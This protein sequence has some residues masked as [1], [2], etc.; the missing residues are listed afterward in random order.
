MNRIRGW[1]FLALSAGFLGSGMAAVGNPE[2]LVDVQ[3]DVLQAGEVEAW[4]NQGTLGGAFAVVPLGGATVGEVEG[5]KAVTFDGRFDMFKSDFPAPDA[6]TGNHPYTVFLRV[7]NPA[8]DPEEC[9]V[10]WARR[11]TADRA[12]QLNYGSS[13]LFGAVTHW[14]GND[15]GF[16][17]GVP[18]PGRWH[19]LAVRYAGGENGLEELFVNAELNA[20]ER[21]TLDLFTG[22]PI[23]LATNLNPRTGFSGSLAEVRIYGY[24]LSDEE[25]A[26]LH[27]GEGEADQQALVKLTAADLPPGRLERWENAGTAGGAFGTWRHVPQAAEVDGRPAVVFGGDAWLRSSF[28]W[29]GLGQGQPFTV[30]FHARAEV[31]TRRQAPL[32]F[33]HADRGE[34]LR[35]NYSANRESGALS[36]RGVEDGPSFR[37]YTPGSGAWHHIAYTWSGAPGNELRVY[38]DGELDHAAVVPMP[39]ESALHGYLGR[40][41]G[42]VWLTEEAD[43]TG[44]LADAQV[45]DRAL[46]QL[47]IRTRLGL[48]S[49]FQPAP[50]DQGSVDALQVNLQWQPGNPAAAGSDLYIGTD[51]AAVAAAGRDAEAYAGRLAADADRFG[52]LDLHLGQTYYWRVDHV[53][54]EGTVLDHGRVWSFS[55][56]TGHAT[57][58]EPR[59]GFSAVPADINTLSWTPGPFTT[60]QT[61]YFGT[62]REAVEAGAEPDGKLALDADVGTLELPNDTLQQGTIYYWRVENRNVEG[63]PV[64]AG[65]VWS[66]RTVDAHKPGHVTFLATSDAHFDNELVYASNLATI[67]MMNRIAGRELPADVGGGM[68][69]TPRGVVINGDLVDHGGHPQ[70]GPRGWAGFVEL[71]GLD[72]RDGRLAY[73]LYEGFGNHDGGPGSVVREGIKTR[74]R[75]RVGLTMVSENGYHYS[76]DWEHVHLVQLNNF[77]GS[78][79]EHATVGP[80]AHHPEHSLEFLKNTLEEH[81]GDS[82]RPVV[83]N[84][85]YGFDGWGMGWFS[86]K[87]RDL[88]YDVIKDYNVVLLIA[89]HNHAAFIGEWRGFRYLSDGAAQRG[90]RPGDFFVVQI[91]GDE[92]VI[93]QWTPDGWSNQRARV[94]IKMPE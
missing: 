30:Q 62:S 65:E 7:L 1:A 35:F 21:K 60:G 12:A 39:R 36:V 24:A 42:G 48:A 28:T 64:T 16:D 61:L 86:E 18:E 3:A 87:A 9:V 44:A 34:F 77:A 45:Y 82:G 46:S 15:M 22:D 6:V 66:F 27:A 63:Q 59:D 13:P 93:A 84:Q 33:G 14:G 85:H 92:M 52:P 90:A 89:G 43:F 5:V 32:A 20:S 73:P 81:V 72:G 91:E 88:L 78:G 37:R 25:L 74:N 55:A 57:Q 69:R 17:G 29:D 79:P 83:I 53:D 76:W 4:A 50:D 2:P 23:Y 19:T 31:G 38:V 54:G 40:S 11:G 70:R 26:R 47:E 80:P 56:P 51:P 71:Y 41:Y 10:Y 49:A 75:Y 58:P 68:V 8:L 94:S 67:E